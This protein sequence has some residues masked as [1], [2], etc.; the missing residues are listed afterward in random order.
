V[1]NVSALV[2]YGVGADGHRR[3]LGITIGPEE[4]EES[5]AELLQQLVQRG[6]HGPAS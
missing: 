6:L 2:A 3:L 5:W 4:S 1:E